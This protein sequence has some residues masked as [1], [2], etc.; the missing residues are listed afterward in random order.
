[1]GYRPPPKGNRDEDVRNHVPRNNRPSLSKSAAESAVNA[2]LSVIG[3]AL[4]RNETLANS[5]FGTF[6]TKH[7]P[8]HRGRN[9][10]TGDSITIAASK[11]PSF[12]ASKALRDAVS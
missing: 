11:V 5:G 9:L 10:R 6:S 4:A 8:Q 1:M 7:R 12:K 2:V 3:D